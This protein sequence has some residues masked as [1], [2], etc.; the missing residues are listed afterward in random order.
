[1]RLRDGPVNFE[2]LAASMSSDRPHRPAAPDRSDRTAVLL[3]LAHQLGEA[4]GMAIMGEGNVSASIGGNRF[5]VKASGTE[6]ATLRE[7]ELVAVDRT[8]LV[9]FF[10]AED[11]DGP[12]LGDEEMEE[13]LLEARVDPE[14]LKPSVETLFHACL[15]GLPE[16]SVV[17]HTHPV[18]VNQLLCSPHAEA[19]ARRRLIPDQIVYCG[20]ESVLVPYVDPGVLLARAIAD[21]IESFRERTGGVPRTILLRNHGLIAVGATAS[22]VKAAILMAEKSARMFVGALQAGGPDFLPEKQVRRIETR[23]DEQ[24]RR[25]MIG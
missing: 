2:P 23:Q 12:A 19:F 21:R 25:E 17:G 18:A 9:P 24:Y 11:E 15:L 10:A 14:A 3:E 16:V 8:R 20:A 5:Q 7:E 4:S 1:M 13:L 6:L 22:E